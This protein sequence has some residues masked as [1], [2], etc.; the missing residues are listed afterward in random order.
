MNN[1]KSR[2]LADTCPASLFRYLAVSQVLAKIAAGE[3]V[4][5][6]VK[7]VAAFPH[8][9][10]DGLDRRVSERTLYRWLAAHRERGLSGLEPVRR[11]RDCSGNVLP[12]E[13]IAFAVAQKAED[14]HASIPDIIQRAAELGILSPAQWVDRTTVYRVLKRMGV[15]VGVRKSVSSRDVRRFAYPHRLQMV[16][17]DGKHFRAGATRARRV[18]LFF[19]DDATRRG[20]DVVVGTAESSALFLRGLHGVARQFGFATIFYLDHGPGFIARDTIDVIAAM[21]C[22]LI[23]GTVAYP[24]G[25]GK[26][27]RFNRTVTEKVL[28]TL[29]RC[30][31]V[32]PDCGALTLRL[33]YWLSE[34]YNHTPHEALDGETPLARFQRDPA[35]LRFA[36]NE[37]DLARRFVVYLERRV[38]ADHVVSVDGVG[39]EMPAGSAGARVVLHRQVLDNTLRVLHQGRL[40][41]LCPVD[42]AANAEHRRAARTSTPQPVEHPL[43]PSAADL[44]HRRAFGCV[45]DDD[46]GFSLP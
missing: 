11:P 8:R 25:H 13:L 36:E 3:A 43:P 4:D 40:I 37:E 27:E 39:Y 41:Q 7:E 23:H 12:D 14:P 9:T 20:L 16:L 2:A 15:A 35:P 6:A 46:G 19:L 24:Q 31:E 21:R 17:A 45:L 38:S 22:L 33:R 28:R 34:T 42:L 18:A 26:I 32:D 10:L 29:D 5:T 1:E 30:P 44:A